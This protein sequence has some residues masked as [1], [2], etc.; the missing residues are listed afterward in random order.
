[1]QNAPNGF[2]EIDPLL[3]LSGVHF[4]LLF[5][6]AA[7]ATGQRLAQDCFRSR[8]FRVAFSLGCRN[9]IAVEK[10]VELPRVA[11]EDHKGPGTARQSKARFQPF[12][13][14]FA[15]LTDV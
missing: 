8:V 10:S 6:E 9:S 1:L 4:T 15:R 5:H 7:F 2:F 11:A 12:Q 14:R 3:S 13:P